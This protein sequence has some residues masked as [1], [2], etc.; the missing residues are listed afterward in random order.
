[1]RS[2]K[3]NLFLT[4][5]F[6]LFLYQ[7]FSQTQQYTA[8]KMPV[9]NETNL[10]TYSEVVDVPGTTKSELYKRTEAWFMSTYKN[11]SEVIRERDSVNLKI[12]GKPRFR[13]TNEPNEKGVKT[14]AGLVQ[15]TITVACRDNKCKYNY[16]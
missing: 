5:L 3:L 11:P 10:I 16:H 6:S 8:P 2:S 7:S 14:D 13:I 15:Y 1:M 12:V 4:A 9:D